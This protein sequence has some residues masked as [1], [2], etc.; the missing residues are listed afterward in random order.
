[1]R[2]VDLMHLMQL[3]MLSDLCAHIGLQACSLGLLNAR[4]V[5][6]VHFS[7]DTAACVSEHGRHGQASRS[8]LTALI[9][10]CSLLQSD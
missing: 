5:V 9:C 4:P 2:H 8:L 3:I 1:M 10:R 6:M 7:A